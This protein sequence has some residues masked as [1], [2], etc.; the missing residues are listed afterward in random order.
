MFLHFGKKKLMLAFLGHHLNK[1]F[2]TVH[3]YDPAWGL[4]CHS[5][6]DELDFVSKSQVCQE[7][8]LQILCF[9]FLSSV[10]FWILVLCS[11]DVVLLLYT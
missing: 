8:K 1:I 11:L 6:L 5:R 3:N 4:H 2:Q 7:Y 10:V 9:G